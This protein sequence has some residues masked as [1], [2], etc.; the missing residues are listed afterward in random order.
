VEQ[1]MREA[2]REQAAAMLGS[3][4]PLGRVANPDESAEAIVCC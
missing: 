1:V 4:I 2:T 3:K